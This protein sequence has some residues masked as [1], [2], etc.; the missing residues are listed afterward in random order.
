MA[1]QQTE[2][3]TLYGDLGGMRSEEMILNMG[4]QHPSTHG[5]LRLVLVLDGETVVQCTPVIGYLHRGMEKI[6]E[7]RPY[8]A[9]IRYIDNADY[10]SVMINET[11]YAGA[12]EQLMDIEPPRRAQYIRLICSELMRIASHLV[13]VGT[14]GL[15]LGA[16]TPVLWCFREREGILDLFE[17]VSGA[18]F[19]H[20]YMRV[21]GVNHDL[22]RG[23]LQRL[24][25]WLDH[26]E[27]VSH[28]E[29]EVLLTGNEIFEART[30]SVGYIDR[31]QAM[32]YALT[33]PVGRGSGV[34]FDIRVDRPYGAYREI[35][36]NPQVRQEG[37]CWARYRVRMQEMLESVRLCRIAMERL[38]GGP[39]SQR[40]PIALRPPRG[41]TYFAVE[42]GRG[43]EAIYLISDGS[44][45]PYRAKLRGPSFVN[46]QILPEL[47][48]GTK[49]GDVIAILGSIDIVLGD[50]DR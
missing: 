1:T 23:W 46:L 28:P 48:R 21:G 37:D 5:V 32:A 3:P 22:P 12:V 31:Q 26:F 16:S 10:L 20:N 11:C 24:E 45:Y 9:G 13:A 27:R 17:E 40:V 49:I 15:D 4:P 35:A 43:E 42:S 18:R 50:V 25:T 14:Y 34:S 47:L 6:F 19:T 8:M 30:Q 38:P 2:N 29:L 44:E 39:I 41:E 7:N 36:V 33:G